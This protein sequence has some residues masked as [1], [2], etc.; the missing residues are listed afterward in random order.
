MINI[1]L[2]LEAIAQNTSTNTNNFNLHRMKNNKTLATSYSY[3]HFCYVYDL[4]AFVFCCLR[5]LLMSILFC[6]FWNYICNIQWRWS[7]FVRIL[8]GCLSNDSSTILKT[9]CCVFAHCYTLD[10]DSKCPMDYELSLFLN[11]FS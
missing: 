3:V 4:L 8:C 11:V 9:C 10:D 5:Y 7:L 2:I 6:L 1:A